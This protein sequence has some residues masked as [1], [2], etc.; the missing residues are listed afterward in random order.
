MILI[1]VISGF[2][3]ISQ[4]NYAYWHIRRFNN[5]KLENS[6]DIWSMRR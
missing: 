6:F 4:I 2:G 3:K 5:E 1:L